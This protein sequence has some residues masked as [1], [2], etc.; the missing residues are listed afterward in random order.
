M[1]YGILEHLQSIAD[2]G[3]EYRHFNKRIVATG[4]EMLGVRMPDLRRFARQMAALPAAELG[5]YLDAELPDD[6]VYE[7]VMLRGLVLAAAAN[8]RRVALEDAFRGL[9][10]LIPLFDSWAHVDVIVSDFK[11]FHKHQD[12]VFARF[13]PLKND[14]GEFTKRTWVILLMDFFLD[15]EHIERTLTELADVGQ[16]QYYVDMAIA[17]ALSVA[18][19]KHYERTVSLLESN[20][21]SHS[22]L[23]SEGTLQQPNG[24]L[25]QPC[26]S[27]FVHNK[28]IQKARESYRISPERKEY[29]NTLKM[30]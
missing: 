10:A 9:D 20:H 19:V 24:T 21:A 26:F 29:L 5:S 18:L 12:E 30:K 16:G 6:A 28:A 8:K 17:W 23:Q 7:E 22:R 15:E 3:D 2:K 11:I 14:A 27:R 4:Y 1:R 13:A 25:S